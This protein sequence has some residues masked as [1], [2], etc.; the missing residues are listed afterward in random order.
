PFHPY[1]DKWGTIEQYFYK[2]EFI[3][4]LYGPPEDKWN[5]RLALAL[6]GDDYEAYSNRCAYDIQSY[7]DLNAALLKRYKPTTSRYNRRLRSSQLEKEE[8]VKLCCKQI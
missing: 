3:A 4:H 6:V 5:I 7:P 2:F 8:I 1:E